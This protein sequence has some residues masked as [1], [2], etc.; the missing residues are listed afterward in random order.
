MLACPAPGATE[1]SGVPARGTVTMVDLGAKSCVPCKLMDPILKRMGK[2][3]A[4]KAAV[5]F[6]DIRYYP[7]EAA[8]FRI[9]SIPTQIFF[10]KEGNEVYRHEG[11]MREEKIIAQFEKMGVK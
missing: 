7:E 6:I 5:V 2:K 1:Y 4:K 3:Y 11:F 9:R 10:D 8:R